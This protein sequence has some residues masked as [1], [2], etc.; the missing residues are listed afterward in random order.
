MCVCVFVFNDRSAGLGRAVMSWLRE[1]GRAAQL[2]VIYSSCTQQ[3]DADLKLI[4]T[5]AALQVR[6]S[7]LRVGVRLLKNRVL[8][9]KTFLSSPLC[10]ALH[11]FANF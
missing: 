9:R 8:I 1:V 4:E 10:L 5:P 7:I 2:S 3:E 11:N 6:L